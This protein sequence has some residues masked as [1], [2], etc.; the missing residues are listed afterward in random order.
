MLGEVSRLSLTTPGSSTKGSLG[1]VSDVELEVTHRGVGP[2][3]FVALHP[4]G[5]EGADTP[6]KF[7]LKAVL[8]GPTTDSDA[9]A[10]PPPPSLLEPVAVLASVLPHVALVVEL[11]TCACTLVL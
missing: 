7:W 9:E 8:S 3:A 6:S 5:S 2:L 10:C 11:T 4:E 1:A